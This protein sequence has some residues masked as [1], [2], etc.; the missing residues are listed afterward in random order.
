MI[1]SPDQINTTIAPYFFAFMNVVQ[2][3]HL[4]RNF[5]CALEGMLK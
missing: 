5:V 3:N 1:P 2:D 4:A